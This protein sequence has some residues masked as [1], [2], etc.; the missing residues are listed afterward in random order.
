MADKQ[1]LKEPFIDDYSKNSENKDPIG[2]DPERGNEL[3]NSKNEENTNSQ[4]EG[5]NFIE[6]VETDPSQGDQTGENDSQ[7][8]FDP[9]GEEFRLGGRMPLLTL[10]ILSIGPII[11][12]IFAS[13]FGVFNS[14]WVTK[15][16]GSQGLEVFGAAFVIDYIQIGFAQYL[17]ISINI[18]ISYLYGEKAGEKCGQLYVDFLRLALVFGSITAAII[19]P[20]TQPLTKWLGAD[21][22]LASM[23]F[24]YVIPEAS[25]SCINY[26][27]MINCGVLQAEGH[28]FYFCFAQ[29]ATFIL[30][31]LVFDPIF[32][33]WIKTPIWGCTLATALSQLIVGTF[34]AVVILKGKFTF[35]PKAKMFV[36]AFTPETWRALLVGIPELVMELSLSVPLIMMQKYIEKAS[37]A[38]GVYAEAMESWAL[39]QRLYTFVEAFELGFVFGYLPAASYAFGAKRYNR[40]LKLTLHLLWLATSIS[41]FLAYAIVIFVK[42][43]SS[44]WSTDETFLEVSSHF[45]PIIFYAMPLIGIA[46]MAPALFEAMQKAISAAVLS[47]LSLL[48]T[49]MTV[50]SIL[51]YTKKNDPYRVMLTYP[52]SDAI[53]ALLY[54]AFVVNPIIFLWKAPKDEWEA[55]RDEEIRREKEEKKKVKQTNKLNE[56]KK[57]K[58]EHHEDVTEDTVNPEPLMN[59]TEEL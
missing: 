13:L 27:Y 54:V 46:Y 6:K 43:V 24:S 4:V 49:P 29:I 14:L 30:N 10:I 34:L 17:M 55:K 50:S 52:I 51:H 39:T 58:K 33:V 8:E 7:N 48:V 42:Q 38:I 45:I 19:I 37:N 36:S 32:F 59:E 25:L 23:C 28:S 15:S 5:Q 11:S 2:S 3:S 9:K 53:G 21:A 1:D 47:V 20:I 31:I 18:R 57:K 16:I 41:T 26:F 22:D 44:I 12:Q 56:L 35:K 40:L